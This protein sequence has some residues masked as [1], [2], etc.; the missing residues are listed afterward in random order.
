MADE[1]Q[2]VW[3][4]IEALRD[5]QLELANIVKGLTEQ[6]HRIDEQL[7]KLKPPQIIPPE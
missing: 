1:Q 5:Q 6:V 4:M 2:V 7:Q 3:E